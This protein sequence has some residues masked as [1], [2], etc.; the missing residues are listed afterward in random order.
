MYNQSWKSREFKGIYDHFRC[1]I[2]ETS[3]TTQLE[4]QALHL[5]VNE[6]Q[7]WPLFSHNPLYLQFTNVSYNIVIQLQYHSLLL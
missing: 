2:T 6:S 3:V 5:F 1:G 4:V 7:Q